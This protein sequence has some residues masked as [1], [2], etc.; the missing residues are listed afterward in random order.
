MS[1][2]WNKPRSLRDIADD[3]VDQLP[4]DEIGGDNV[5]PFSNANAGSSAAPN[6]AVS[7]DAPMEEIRL[8]A[9]RQLVTTQPIAISLVFIP[10]SVTMS[11]ISSMT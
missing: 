5:V 9:S 10:R 1:D 8:K 3:L 2:F 11:R 6:P 4:D 7:N